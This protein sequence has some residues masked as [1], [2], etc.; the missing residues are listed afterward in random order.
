M[1]LDRL[2]RVGWPRHFL[3][4]LGPS[5]LLAAICISRILKSAGQPAF[6]LDDAFIHLQYASRLASG[7]GFEYT[8]GGG[9]SSG[10]TSFAW[11]LSLVPFFAMGLRDLELVWV[12]WAM[13]TMLHAA[14]AYETWRFGRRLLGGAGGLAAAAACSAFGA[15]AWFAWSGMETMALAWILVRTA[16]VA[17]DHAERSD[18]HRTSAFL[19]LGL[20]GLF[21]PLIRPEGALASLIV[22]CAVAADWK[23]RALRR[24]GSA[25][26]GAALVGPLVVPLVHRLGAGHSASSTAMVKHLAFDPYLDGAA[27]LD[28]TLSNVRMLATEL[29]DGGRY[30]AEFLPSGFAWF[31]L[32]GLLAL[33][34]LARRTG[35]WF[36]A[37]A[38]LL[39]ALGTLGPATYATLLW[40]RVRYI[41]PFAPS[42][43]LLVG[44]FAVE[45]GHRASKR[46]PFAGIVAPSIGW[47]LVALLGA[48]L[49]F[50][51]DDLAN[52]A[53][54]ISEQQVH[55]GRWA[56]EH[57]PEDALVGVSDTGAI[58]YFSHRS[59][60][61][62]V[63][64][65]TEGEAP[66]WALGAGARFEHWERRRAKGERL[67]THLVL[68]RSWMGMPAVE[69][70]HLTEATVTNQSILGGATMTAMEA[71]YELFGSGDSPRSN[72]TGLLVGELDVADRESE[73]ERSYVLGDARSHRCVARVGAS[74]DGRLL[75]DGGR[76]ER[77]EDRFR[78]GVRA[79]L[80]LLMRVNKGCSLEVLVDGASVGIARVVDEG[81]TFE[82][83]AIELPEGGDFATVRCVEPRR[84]SSYHYWWFAS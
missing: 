64:L 40:N 62:V 59:T 71:D 77:A 45:L 66:Y 41:W 9:Y 25:A 5:T 35:L 23:R 73:L 42:W 32:G 13:G 83:R 76:E 81:E 54:A 37:F 20:L 55:L 78:L 21:A 53:R 31:V 3:W 61:D 16:R 79:R 57:L 47:G 7:H 56:R 6:P 19:Q 26:F 34:F 52:S 12:A 18:P 70:A 28:A 4:A 14:V 49:D 82:E 65:T 43:F 58:A 80:S 46:A 48:K 68:Y 44:T 63:G 10:A 1:T 29:L 27:V 2:R 11:P 39:L 60:F 30:T 38:L 17:S 15:F 51:T 36:R 50:A 67:P 24:R 33:P 74:S 69:G 22:A 75:A 8:D 72:H 84:F